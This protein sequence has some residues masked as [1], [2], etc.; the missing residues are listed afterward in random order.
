[1]VVWKGGKSMHVL[2]KFNTW[3]AQDLGVAENPPYFINE[4]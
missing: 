2:P 4:V 3:W 1:M